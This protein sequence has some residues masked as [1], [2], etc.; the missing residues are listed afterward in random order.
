MKFL[1]L[2]WN[3]KSSFLQQFGFSGH[4]RLEIGL[5]CGF[6]CCDRLQRDQIQSNSFPITRNEQLAADKSTKKRK[7]QNIWREKFFSSFF[8]GLVF[9]GPA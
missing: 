4:F 2:Y 9:L 8:K 5:L 3:C 7:K 6:F 1:N